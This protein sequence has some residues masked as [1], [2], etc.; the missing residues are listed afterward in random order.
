MNFSK[1]KEILRQ[2]EVKKIY[3]KNLAPND[4]SKNQVYLGGSFEILNIF[5]IK[6][7]H[8]EP[9]GEW[10][11]ERF[12]ASVHFYWISPNGELSESPEAQLILYPKYPEVRLSG[13]LKGCNNPPSDLMKQRTKDRILL[14]GISPEGFIIAHVCHPDSELAREIESQKNF[15]MVGL[16]KCFDI[17]QQENSKKTLLNELLRVHLKGWMPSRRLDKYGNSIDCNAPNCGGYTLEAE[18]GISP[19]GYSEPDF[20]GWEVKQFSAKRNNN[21]AII[22]LM[23]PEPTDGEYKEKG[24]E[25]FIRT[26]GYEDKKGREDRIN[27]G[28]IY[29]IGEF[30]T[31]KTLRMELY[32]FDNENGK[33]KNTDGKIA[34]LDKN[35]NEAASWSF[36]SL[37]KHWNR[38]HNKACYVPSL[39]KTDNG[40]MYRFDND[41]LLGTGTDFQLFLLQISRGL[42]YYDPAIK[43][44][45]QATKPLIK[46]RS[47]FRTKHQNIQHLYKRSERGK[48]EYLLENE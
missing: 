38:K 33:I 1:I 32:G 47:Q 15:E 48:I 3:I 19:N 14:L 36:T 24:V 23:T 46:R 22:T 12:K 11:R 37:M 45:N 43:L 10:K 4:N 25:Y 34:L 20:L 42:I 18:L 35:D 26:Y 39:C 9:A 29:K 41:I 2:K 8:S 5:P 21:S 17:E 7:I 27:F 16:F 6:E 30:S 31:T 13:F 40:R 44:E 28:G